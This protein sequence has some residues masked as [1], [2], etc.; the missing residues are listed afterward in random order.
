M[1]QNPNFPGLRPRTPLGEIQL[2]ELLI[3]LMIDFKCR[4]I[5]STYFFSI[6]ERRKWIPWWRGWWGNAPQNFWAR[7]APVFLSQF[8]YLCEKNTFMAENVLRTNACY[9]YLREAVKKNIAR[10][11][12]G[13][14]YEISLLELV[15]YCFKA[16]VLEA[17]RRDSLLLVF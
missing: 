10:K 8:C 5:W 3:L 9:M 13:Y 4:P 15:A 1:L 12:R 6:G 7:T 17:F 14:S 11:Y 16:S 2:T